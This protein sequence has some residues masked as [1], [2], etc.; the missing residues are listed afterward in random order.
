MKTKALF[1]QQLTLQEL[2]LLPGGEWSPRL[3][4]WTLLRIDRGAGYWLNP[5]VHQELAENTVVVL[6]HGATGSIRSSQLGETSLQFLFVQP[7]S[8]SG[9]LTLTEQKVLRGA[10]QRDG[11]AARVLAA[12]EPLAAEFKV[13]A[14][15]S[16]RTGPGARLRWLELFLEVFENDFAAGLNER[17]TDDD[18]KSRLETLLSRMSPADLLETDFGHFAAQVGCSPRHL[19]RLFHEVLGQSFREKQNEVRLGRARELLSGSKTKIIEVALES[20][21][22]SLS[23]FNLMFKRHC[24]LTPSEWREMQV[25]RRSRR[26]AVT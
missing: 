3:P 17:V 10:L 5:Q 4:G 7:E 21:F 20:G 26:G 11:G 9:L 8:L 2:I 25:A 6:P 19:G 18:A 12:S 13:I 23:L 24:G 16:N 1:G 14:N 15:E 22:Q